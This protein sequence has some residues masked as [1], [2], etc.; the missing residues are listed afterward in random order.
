MRAFYAD[1][2]RVVETWRGGAR[3]ILEIG[4]RAA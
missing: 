2:W 3:P 4:R 1:A